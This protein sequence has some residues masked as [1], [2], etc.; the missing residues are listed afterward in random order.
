MIIQWLGTKVLF[1]LSRM[2]WIG[3]VLFVI[4][5][6]WIYL[7]AGERADDK[8]NQ[9]I[10]ATVEREKQTGEVLKRTEKANEVR[11]ATRRSNDVAYA[12]CVQSARTPA[13]CVGLLP[14]REVD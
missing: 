14:E 4:A 10:G 2:V 3:I 1:G 6:V 11:E 13:N 9:E 8:N 12:E 7:D 5:G